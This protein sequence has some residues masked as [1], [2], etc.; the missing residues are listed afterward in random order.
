MPGNRDAVK[1][2]TTIVVFFCPSYTARWRAGQR[3]SSTRFCLCRII[4]SLLC[5]SVSPVLQLP[6][7]VAV[8]YS[9]C[10]CLASLSQQRSTFYP[11]LQQQRSTFSPAARV[12]PQS[13][14]PLRQPSSAGVVKTSTPQ[15]HSSDQHS[16][17]HHCFC[18][19]T[20]SMP[21]LAAAAH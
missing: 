5:L 4:Y 8:G 11:F 20:A 21:W 3:D 2:K 7:V 19:G 16:P 14:H 12:E 10:C 9:V 15:H 1:I 13:Q 6:A 17:I 18:Q